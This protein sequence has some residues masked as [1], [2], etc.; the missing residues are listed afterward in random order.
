VVAPIINHHK[1]ILF[2]LHLPDKPKSFVTLEAL[3]EKASTSRR[4]NG[5]SSAEN[6]PSINPTWRTHSQQKWLRWPL[7]FIQGTS[8]RI[9]KLLARFNITSH[10]PYK[11]DGHLLRPVKNALGLKVT[12]IPCKCG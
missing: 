6:P 3:V 5:Y 11:T 9:S 4:Q 8:S 1:N 7:H 12:A 10:I 2:F